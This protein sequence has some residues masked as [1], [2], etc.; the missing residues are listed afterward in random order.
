MSPRPNAEGSVP[1]REH[2]W[3]R[4]RR[5]AF[6]RWESEVRRVPYDHPLPDV[7]GFAD[8]IEP[9]IQWADSAG[10]RRFFALSA[11]PTGAGASYLGTLP[12]RQRSPPEGSLVRLAHPIKRVLPSGD[13]PYGELVIDARNGIQPASWEEILPGVSPRSVANTVPELARLWRLSPET[14]E[15]L[16]L[17][18]VGS[19]PWH[20]R[21]AG[22]ELYAEVEGWSLAQHRSFLTGVLD[23]APDWVGNA[24]RASRESGGVRELASGARIRRQS[25]GAARPFALQL[26]SMSGPR[27]PLTP[28]EPVPRSVINYGRALAAEFGGAVLAGHSVLLLSADDA[29]NVPRTPA[30][31]PDEL[32][33]T[34]WGLHWWNPEPPDAPDWNRWLRGQEERLREALGK[35]PK[36]PEAPTE[37]DP[38]GVMGRREFRD[39]LAQTAFARARLRGAAEVEEKDLNRT[40]QSL[41]RAIQR[42]TDWA[43][44]GRGPLSRAVDRTEGAHTSRLRRTLEVLLQG[45]AEGLTSTEALAT[46]RSAGTLA[47]GWDVENQLERLRIRGLLFQ[48]RAGRYRVA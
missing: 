29:G 6:A 7:V 47:S 5:L 41:T 37:T 3:E 27:A 32:R 40:V 8:R 45:R 23:L 30:E 4:E 20:G 24:R 1:R 12:A 2:P 9:P 25:P 48:D 39:R 26:R 46:L 17:P 16:L 43:Q 15:T 11:L 34:I 18:L 35:L 44:V 10:G 14:V 19:L 38:Q 33:T 28:T 42:A 21:P 31:L 22:L 36:V 13:G